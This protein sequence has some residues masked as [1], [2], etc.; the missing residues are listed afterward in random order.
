MMGARAEGKLRPHSVM[1]KED[2]SQSR[3]LR[4]R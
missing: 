2:V 3:E 1:V 4:W